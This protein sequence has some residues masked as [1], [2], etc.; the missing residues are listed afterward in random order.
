MKYPGGKG[1]SFPHIIN[2]MPPHD[3]YIESHLGGGA[4]MRNKKPALKQIGIERDPVVAEKWQRNY[5]DI[6]TLIEGDAVEY[7]SKLELNSKTLIYID[8]PYHPKTRKRKR[9]YRHDYVHHD[10]VRLLKLAKSL[11]CYVLISGYSNDLYE[12]TLSDWSRHTFSSKA[13]DGNRNE[14]VWFNYDKPEHLHDSRY[15]GN[16][17]REREVVKRRLGRLQDRISSLSLQERSALYQWM[18]EQQTG[19]FKHD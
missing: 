16:T 12:S 1:K 17:F 4:V 8:P 7:L 9:V 13:H 10:H 3:C 11:N 2:L 5:G 14:V 19:E 15:I 6:C 18:R